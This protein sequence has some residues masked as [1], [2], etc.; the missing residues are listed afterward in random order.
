MV[1]CPHP[2]LTISSKKYPP[3]NSVP[4]KESSLYLLNSK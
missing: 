2:I 4:L 1:I 3:P